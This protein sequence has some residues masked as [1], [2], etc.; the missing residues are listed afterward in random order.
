MFFYLNL[1]IF[2]TLFS[3]SYSKTKDVIFAQVSKISVFLLMFI[4]AS[5][6]YGVGTDYF[7]YIR[8]FNIISNSRRSRYEPGYVA[9]NQLCHFLDLDVQWVFVIMAFLTLFFL[10]LAVQ[11]K[12]FY[13]IIPVYFC[14][15]Y[16]FSYNAVRNAL[17][18]TI[19][20]YAY[21]LFSRKKVL[22]S[23][24]MVGIASLF[25]IS[26]VLFY[27]IFISMAMFKINKIQ[28]V[29][30]FIVSLILFFYGSDIINLVFNTMIPQT[31][32]ASYLLP[33]NEHFI[34]NRNDMGLF[35]IVHFFVFAVVLFFLPN[36][37]NKDAS[38]IFI[39]FLVSHFAYIFATLSEILGRLN[40]IFS[41]AW[42]PLLHYIHT[43]TTKFRKFV[44]LFI[45]IWVSISFIIAVGVLG[46]SNMLP[47]RT[48]FDK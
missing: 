3:F 43:N 38:N 44:L 7:S 6:R 32:Y 23:F 19:A 9:I 16:A 2:I 34:Q 40:D 5:L 29:L 41:I 1:F 21:Q 24:V 8:I 42:F 36:V 12:S 20:Y 46:S 14:L 48:I 33:Q 15:F 45:F 35:T 22:F 27:L 26:S 25:H 17:A 13:I 4:P 39:F 31:R 30:I 10:F 28:A 18:I 11:R 47:Y 37:K